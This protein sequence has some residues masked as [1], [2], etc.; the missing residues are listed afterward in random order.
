MLCS[1]LPLD[2]ADYGA[3]VDEIL[4]V[5]KSMPKPQ[6]NALKSAFIFSRKAPREEREDLFQEIVLAILKANTKDEKLAYAIA[7][8]DWKDFWKAYSTRQHYFGGYLGQTIENNDGTDATPLSELIVGECE[9]ENKMNGNLQAEK[10]WAK[11]P[12][13]IKTIVNRR[14]QGYALKGNERVTLHRW[15]KREGY[16][17]LLQPA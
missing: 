13:D 7:R 17:L 14:L 1:H 9:F 16:K 5:I 12:A 8:C 6:K 11:L 4:N 3:K 15:I 2:G 10:I